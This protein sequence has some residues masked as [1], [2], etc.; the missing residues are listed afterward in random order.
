MPAYW[1]MTAAAPTTRV[2]I[3]APSLP[4]ALLTLKAGGTTV[5]R[6]GPAE[7]PRSPDNRPVAELDRLNTYRQ[8]A[9]ALRGGTSLATALT[10]LSR[11]SPNPRMA[12]ALRGMGEAVAAGASLAEAM[13]PYGRLFAPEVVAV[14]RAAEVSGR[15]PEALEDLAAQGE[16]TFGLLHRASLALLYPLFVA[17]LATLVL[18]FYCSFLAPKMISLFRELGMSDDNFPTITLVLLWVSQVVPKIVTPLFLA[19]LVAVVIYFVYRRSAAGRLELSYWWLRVPVLGQLAFSAAVA[20][21]LA[22]LGLL[23]RHR[24]AAPQALR[25][26]G[27][28]SGSEALTAAMRRAEAVAAGGESL[29]ASLREAGTLAPAFLWRLGSA[30]HS[31]TLP[32]ACGVIAGLYVAQTEALT[33]RTMGLVEPFAILLLGLVVA[34]VGLGMFLPLISIISELSQ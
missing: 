15:L 20:R 33:R 21:M 11:D 26:A 34:A 14:V 32:E 18:T 30:E 2:V 22:T 7:A 23:I 10:L 27:E 3:H 29:T 5:A 6:C 24:V 4:A 25:L 17:C 16:A 8:L 1:Y 9:A 13:A 12:G 31:G 19:A 28:A